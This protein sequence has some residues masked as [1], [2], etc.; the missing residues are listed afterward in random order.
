MKLHSLDIV[1]I[2]PFLNHQKVDFDRLTRNGLFLIDGPTGAGKS[3]LID[4]ITFALYGETAGKE[5]SGSR[6]RSQWSTPEDES[7]VELEFS[8]GTRRFRI[9]RT[10]EYMRAAKRGDKT[11]KQS[12]TQLLV[13]LSADG[14][15]LRSW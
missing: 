4:A 7:K 10:P 12:E 9:T 1:G 15:D 8:I 13:E 5:S 14:T 2:G 3:T 6:I 11:V